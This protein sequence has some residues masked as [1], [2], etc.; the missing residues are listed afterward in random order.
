[1]VHGDRRGTTGLRGWAGSCIHAGPA[2]FWSFTEHKIDPASC[3]S[4]ARGSRSNRGKP[5]SIE[6][7]NAARSSARL[8]RRIGPPSERRYCA[9]RQ[10][11][12]AYSL[13]IAVCEPRTACAGRLCCGQRRG[14]FRSLAE[15]RPGCYRQAHT[16]IPSAGRQCRNLSGPERRCRS[17]T[18]YRRGSCRCYALSLSTSA[19]RGGGEPRCR[20][21]GGDLAR[22]SSPHEF[23]VESGRGLGQRPR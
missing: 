18:G 5:A 4:G 11:V 22:R 2:R 6:K 14:R 19:S 16:G 17:H 12:L 20:N 3:D 1:M 15:S 7:G 9:I 23:V 10:D 8:T 13:A 21:R